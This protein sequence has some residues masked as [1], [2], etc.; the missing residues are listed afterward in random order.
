MEDIIALT[1][2]EAEAAILNDQDFLKTIEDRL[3][4]ARQHKDDLLVEYQRHVATHH[5]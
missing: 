4:K 1:R 5:C 2:R 3:E